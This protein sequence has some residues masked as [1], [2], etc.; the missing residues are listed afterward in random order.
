MTIERSEHMTIDGVE[1]EPHGEPLEVRGE[2]WQTMA[3]ISESDDRL[4]ELGLDTG[5]II[6]TR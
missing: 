3:P 6:R 5:R 1:V 2:Q 4:W